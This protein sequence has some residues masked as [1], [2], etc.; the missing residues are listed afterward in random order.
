MRESFGRVRSRFLGVSW[1]E[2]VVYDDRDVYPHMYF[3]I[4]AHGYCDV[5]ILCLFPGG[6]GR[7]FDTQV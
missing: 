6:R 3:W 7:E 2:Y 1:G 5:G 4:A